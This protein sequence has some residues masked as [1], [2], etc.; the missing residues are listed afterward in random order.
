MMDVCLWCPK[1]GWILLGL[2]VVL[3]LL[4]MWFGRKD[5]ITR[6]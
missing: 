3:M 2:A 4:I 6:L 5:K 1:A